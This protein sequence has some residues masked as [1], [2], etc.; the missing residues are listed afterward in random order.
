MSL[1]V[2]AQEKYQLVSQ[3]RALQWF[4]LPVMLVTIALGWKYPLLGFTVAAAMATG[5]I[6][7]VL[8]G[9]YVCGNLCPR[10]AFF[11][12]MVAPFAPRRKL[13][14]WMRGL[15]FRLAVLAGLMGFMIWRIAQNPGDLNHWGLV[16]WSM[17]AL[18]TAVGLGL[19][20][21]LHPRAWCAICPMG[22]L[23]NLLGGHKQPLRIA[24][25]CRSCGKCEAACPMSL[26]IMP[27]K[28][29]GALKD[30]DCLKCPEC[31][32][33]CPVNALSWPEGRNG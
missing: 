29:A 27:D 8:R 6:G 9:R 28:K 7:G 19:A 31:I 33:A 18:T 2:L 23:Q 22:T 3:R 32:A 26:S 15:P 11:D 17:C 14:A 5:M 20:F 4:L 13:P 16:F 25:S 30:R 10:G 24:A 1:N 12:R 21:T